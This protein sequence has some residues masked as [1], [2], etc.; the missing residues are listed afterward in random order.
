[1]LDN[2]NQDFGLPS[3]QLPEGS[4]CRRSQSYKSLHKKCST[5]SSGGTISSPFYNSGYHFPSSE[6][7]QR[8][9]KISVIVVDESKRPK[10]EVEA[11]PKSLDSQ[12]APFEIQSSIREVRNKASSCH[13]RSASFMEAYYAPP[14]LSQMTCKDYLR[15]SGVIFSGLAI[16]GIIIVSLSGLIIGPVCLAVSNATFRTLKL[17]TVVQRK[18]HVVALFCC[19]VCVLTLMLLILVL[20]KRQKINDRKAAEQ[21]I[22]NQN[23]YKYSR[24][25]ST[26]N[27]NKIAVNV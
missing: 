13:T 8:T 16:T 5:A 26:N 6:A 12:P 9:R 11:S 20:E 4:N 23:Y 10:V 19:G 22:T 21:M 25:F 24:R 14:K 15:C 17:C 2:Q 1:M 3:N 7:S 18:D 27:H